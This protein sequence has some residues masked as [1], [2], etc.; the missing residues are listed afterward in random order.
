MPE[1]SVVLPVFNEAGN[2][3]ELYRRLA[4][5]LE[6]M[7]SFELI[8]VDDGSADDTWEGIRRLSRGEPDGS[9]S[10][11][12]VSGFRVRGLRF[13]RNFGHHYAVAAGLEAASGG[14]V[15]TMD[16]DLQ[17]PPEEIPRLLDALDGGSDAVIGVKAHKAHSP[18]KRATS[19]VYMTTMALIA[20]SKAPLD[21]SLFRAMKADFVKDVLERV[22]PDLFLPTLYAS[23]GRPQA[24]V[25]IRHDPRFAGG[26]KYDMARMARLAVAGLASAARSGRGA[27]GPREGRL[28]SFREKIGFKDTEGGNGTA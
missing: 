16:A 24:L 10:D 4:A 14:V 11:P 5:V 17:D 28:Y 15:I 18:F 7:G 13:S 20:R 22:G 9:S 12:R 1:F 2:L 21:S 26:T 23:I 25:P 19:W 3:N 27:G 6:P 8:F